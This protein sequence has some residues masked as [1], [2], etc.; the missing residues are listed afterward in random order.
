MARD[1]ATRNPAE[2]SKTNADQNAKAPLRDRPVAQPD[3]PVSDDLGPNGKAKHAQAEGDKSSQDAD[4]NG[5]AHVRVAG[6]K[7]MDMPPKHWS[8]TDEEGDES[9]PASDPPG[10]Y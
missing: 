5:Q 6:R 7:E 10:N 2:D 1:P 9:F 4:E 8:K 3:R